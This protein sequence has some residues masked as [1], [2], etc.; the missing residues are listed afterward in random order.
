MFRYIRFGRL[1]RV[2]GEISA[3]RP[4]D[5][6]RPNNCLP[7]TTVGLN[8]TTTQSN[9]DRGQPCPPRKRQ[10]PDPTGPGRGVRAV[11]S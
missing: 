5:D 8:T 2:S 9:Q 11:C 6:A 1:S 3:R 7:R 10:R 4:L